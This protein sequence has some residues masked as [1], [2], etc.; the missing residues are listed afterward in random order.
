MT[1]TANKF[2]HNQEIIICP[3]SKLTH[4]KSKFLHIELSE[5]IIGNLAYCA[6]A[7]L[8]A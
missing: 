4:Y 5:E 1:L 6:V 2:D 8:V 3:D 7:V